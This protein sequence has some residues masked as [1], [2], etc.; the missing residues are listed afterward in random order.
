MP[1]VAGPD[2]IRKRL[3]D[4]SKDVGKR[5]EFQDM[6][7]VANVPVPG[8]DVEVYVALCRFTDNRVVSGLLNVVTQT[9]QSVGALPERR[10]RPPPVLPTGS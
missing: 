5:I 10:R 6:G 7:V 8:D 1:F 4:A 3:G 9:A 2:L